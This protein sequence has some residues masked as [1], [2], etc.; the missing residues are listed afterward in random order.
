MPALVIHESCCDMGLQ[1]GPSPQVLFVVKTDSQVTLTQLRNESVTTRSRHLQTSLTMLVT[2]VMAQ[3]YILHQSRP[4][5]SQK[6]AK[7]PMGSQK[8][9][10]VL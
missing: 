10:L 3:V 6:G 7:R 1:V 4:S 9:Y 5:L 8:C 2:C